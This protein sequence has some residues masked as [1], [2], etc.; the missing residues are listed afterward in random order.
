M[1]KSK[2]CKNILILS[3]DV[4]GTHMAGPGIRYYHLARILSREFSVTLAI[5][6]PLESALAR[7][8]LKLVEYNPRD[9]HT[10]AP[11]LAEAEVVL[12]NGYLAG[13]V[14][15]SDFSSLN[16]PVIIDGY[17]PHLATWLSATADHPEHQETSWKDQ[18]KQLTPQYL[19]GDFFICASERQRDWWLGLLE[20]Y[21]RINPW[22]LRG[23]ASLRRLVDVVPYGLPEYAPQHTR[24]V[25]RGVWPNIGERDKIL[26]WGGGL[27][28]WLDPLTAVKALEII[29]QQRQDV[30]LVFPGTRHPNPANQTLSAQVEVCRQRASQAGLLD[31]AVFFSEWVPYEDWPNFLLESDLALALHFE[32]TLETHWAFRTRLLDYIWASLPTVST[33]GDVTSEF[34]QELNLGLLVKESDSQGVAEAILTLLDTPRQ[35]FELQFALAR[36]R[37]SWEKV[38]LPL[39][40]FCHQPRIAPDKQ[41]LEQQVGNPYYR[42]Y[43]DDHERLVAENSQLNALVQAYENRRIIR[44]LNKIR[45]FTRR[46]G[47]TDS[48]PGT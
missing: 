19:I 48:S 11:L 14:P 13:I 28:P 23:D 41:A 38:A 7:E 5:P 24:P 36:Q 47:F 46:L 21:G 17:D 20:G 10:M 42:F 4:I 1:T 25:M 39:V 27:W 30:R 31:R 44:L 3:H 29:W 9:W 26:L 35:Q 33:R 45:S 8:N 12:L 6:R 32:E 15:D 22:T 37:F 16:I 18:I 40:S 34:I 2:P 43:Q